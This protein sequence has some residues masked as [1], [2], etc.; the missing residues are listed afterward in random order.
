MSSLSLA[1]MFSDHYKILDGLCPDRIACATESGL[2]AAARES[3]ASCRSKEGN[4][5]KM[6]RIVTGESASGTVMEPSHILDAATARLVTNIWGFD[7]MPELPLS[8]EAAK[9]AYKQMGVFGPTGAVRV[10]VIT[11]PP[12]KDAPPDLAAQ[13]SGLDLGTG[14]AMTPGP[15]TGGMHR[16]DSIDLAIVV[17]GQAHVVYPVEG[18]KTKE[19]AIREGDF[20]VQNGAFHDWQNRSDVPCVIFLVMFAAKRKAT[21]PRRRSPAA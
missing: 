17:K 1:R 7:Q 12:A 19:I 10:N 21:E 20:I 11:L 4:H 13:V 15:G 9:A 3:A 18:G 16:T 14:G 8:P 2:Q 5:L 6:R